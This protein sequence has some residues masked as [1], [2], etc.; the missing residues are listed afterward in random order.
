MKITEDVRKYAAEQ[1]SQ[2]QQLSKR[3]WN[4]RQRSST[5]LAQKF[6][7]RHNV[8]GAVAAATWFESLASRIRAA[9]RLLAE[10]NLNPN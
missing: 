8:W 3:D 5:K 9:F 10:T 4:R 1:G 7:G 2:K 6:I